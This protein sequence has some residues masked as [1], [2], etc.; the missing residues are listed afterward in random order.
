MDFDILD[1]QVNALLG[2]S[3]AG[4]ST[5][6][7]IVMGFTAPDSGEVL[8]RDRPVCEAPPAAFRRCNQMVFQNP[9]LAVN[10]LFTVGQIIGEPLRTLKAAAPGGRGKDRRDPGAAGAARGLCAAAAA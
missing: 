5:L 7:R 8:Y 2:R 10:P 9:F 1:G 3:G 4:K 6:A